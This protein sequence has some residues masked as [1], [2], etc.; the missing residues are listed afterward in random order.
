MVV[1]TRRRNSSINAAPIAKQAAASYLQQTAAKTAAK[2][3]AARVP[4]AA[5]AAA[6]VQGCVGEAAAARLR[7]QSKSFSK[8]DFASF[9]NN[10]EVTKADKTKTTASIRVNQ[11]TH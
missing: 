4:A 6:A 9:G 5:A 8:I 11:C 2:P 7:T 3:A 10:F 1:S